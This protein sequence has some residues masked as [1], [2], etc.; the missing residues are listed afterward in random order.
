MFLGAR[1]TANSPPGSPHGGLLGLGTNHQT[2]PTRFRSQARS[3]L[4]WHRR[5]EGTGSVG[6][7]GQEKSGRLHQG[8]NR[9]DKRA[10]HRDDFAANLAHDAAAFQS[11][12]GAALAEGRAAR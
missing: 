8:R 3:I 11:P 4:S 5:A 9:Y 2:W 7:T 12:A 10:I 1:R 6:N